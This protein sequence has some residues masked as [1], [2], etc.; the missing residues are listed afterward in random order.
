MERQEY[1]SGLFWADKLV[2]LSCGEADDVLMQAKCLFHLK[3]YHRA[4]HCI[5]SRNLHL[6]SLPC[7]HL[8]AK[9]HVS[10]LSCAYVPQ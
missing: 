2:C 9:S 8:I 1:K 7:R 5:T 6:V 10:S 4:I 3:E